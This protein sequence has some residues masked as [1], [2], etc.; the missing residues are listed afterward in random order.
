VSLAPATPLADILEADWQ[1]D[2]VKL[3]RTL[4]WDR[5]YHTFN[6]RRSAHGFPDLVL[7]RDRCVM[8]ELKRE[9]TGL[10]DEQ[11]GW[12]RAL[13]AADVETYVI[14]PRNLEQIAAILASRRD[15]S[16]GHLTQPR[17]REAEHELLKQL[18]KEIE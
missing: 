2:V 5:I 18:R 17:A 13:L 16:G 8:L 4:G 15:P 3:A 10:T 6:S 11:A 12:L 9:K 1:R 14:R 7:L